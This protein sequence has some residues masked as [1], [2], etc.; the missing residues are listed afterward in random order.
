MLRPRV[1][2]LHFFDGFRTSHEV[3]MITPMRHDDLRAVVDDK[4]VR[5]HRERAMFPGPAHPARDGCA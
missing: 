1:P 4:F 2:F 3:N 5:Q